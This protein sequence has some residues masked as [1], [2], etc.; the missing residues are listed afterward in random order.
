M[1]TN[2]LPSADREVDPAYEELHSSLVN[3]YDINVSTEGAYKKKNKKLCELGQTERHEYRSMDK[4]ALMRR[5]EINPM[6]K[7]LPSL[8]KV[9]IGRVSSA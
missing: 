9:T 2:E 3:F 1:W 8:R 4:S 7:G 5:K 6:N